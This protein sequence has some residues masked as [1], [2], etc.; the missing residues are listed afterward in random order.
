MNDR[1]EIDNV[2]RQIIAALR[3]DGRATNQ[4][5]A[6]DLGLTAATVSARIKRMEDANKL[7]VVAVSDFS[8]HGFNIMMEVAIEVDGRPASEVAAEL[9]E[10]PEVFAAHLVTGRYDIDLLVVLRSFDDLT[11]LMSNRLSKVAGI[12]SMMPAIAVDVVKYQFDVAP[13]DAWDQS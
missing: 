9:A 6:S 4:Q 11:E 13:I 2:D 5:I 12:R 10:L 8:A 3:A 7:R 1:F